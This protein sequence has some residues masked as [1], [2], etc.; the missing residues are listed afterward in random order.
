LF[1]QTFGECANDSADKDVFVYSKL[2]LFNRA[3]IEA[4]NSRQNVIS[5][6]LA[7]G[8]RGSKN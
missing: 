6:S 8:Q 2:V 3:N 5:T 4:S 1:P 7:K